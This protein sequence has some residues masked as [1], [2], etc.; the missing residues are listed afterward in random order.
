MAA[1][2]LHSH[3]QALAAR[4]ALDAVDRGHPLGVLPGQGGRDAHLDA[5]PR[6]GP[7][8][9]SVGPRHRGRAVLSGVA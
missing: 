3:A 8:L 6:G 5:W 7:P 1:T 4:Q 2:R 9:D